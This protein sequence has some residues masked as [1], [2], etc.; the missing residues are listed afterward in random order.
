[1]ADFFYTVG[2]FGQWRHF[3]HSTLMNSDQPSSPLIGDIS[4]KMSVR[5][6]WD[7]RMDR[8]AMFNSVPSGRKILLAKIDRAMN[9][10]TPTKLRGR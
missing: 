5:D 3:R 4:V 9:V 6:N 10:H 1:M 8:H 2:M 7:H